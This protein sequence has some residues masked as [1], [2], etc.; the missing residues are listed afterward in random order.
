MKKLT[1]AMCTSML[2]LGL[3][4]TSSAQLLTQNRCQNAY[5]IS[6]S[7]AQARY[8]W[9]SYCRS[10]PAGGRNGTVYLSDAS[11]SDYNNSSSLLRPWLFP[12]YFNYM[13]FTPWDIPG[14][15]YQYGNN[16]TA[17]PDG[18]WNVGLCVAGCFPADA[19]VTFAEGDVE[20]KEA[21][22]KGRLD[23]V[24]LSPEASLDELDYIENQV[25]AYTVDIVEAWQTIYTFD[26]KSGGRLRVTDAH[27]V[28][29]ADGTMRVAK[30]LEVGDSLVRAD[31][32]ED[33]IADVQVDRF[34]GKVYHVKPTTL[35]YS[36]NIIVAQGYLNGSARYQ[37]EFLDMVNGV[38]LRRSL[39]RI[40][41]ND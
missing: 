38:I 8:A 28:L 32:S 19:Q 17:L 11:I 24:T 7:T 18:T 36:S 37:N 15:A 12:T 35:D 13:N 6:S 41:L 40:S 31:G 21:Y 2:L 23:L 27:P 5:G 10:N 4:G 1:I 20:I 22:D 26:M 14:S 9:A 16:C 33:P 34:F 3:Q 29:V 30:S 25:E 39:E